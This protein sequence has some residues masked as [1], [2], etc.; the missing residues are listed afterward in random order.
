MKK[1]YK[2]TKKIIGIVL[3]FGLISCDSYLSELPDD[4]ATIDSPDKISAL[5][6]GAYPI[7]NYMLMAELMSDNALSKPSDNNVVDEQLHEQMF[8]WETNEDDSGNQDTPTNYWVSC[9]E[10]IGQANQALESIAELENIHNLNAQKGEALLARAYAHFMLVNFWGKHYN[11][12]SAST[13][14]GVPYVKET[15]TVLFK[16]YKRN[17]V[18]EV[19]DFIEAD[20]IQGIE[21]VREREE[22]PKFHFTTEAAHAFAA[23]FYAFKADWDKVIAHAN[24]ILTNPR[25]QIRDMIAYSDLTY[26]ARVFRYNNTIENAN[27]LVN[28]SLSWW[29]R[30]FASSNYGLVSGEG[31]G[32]LLGG[33]PL[34]KSWAYD[35]FGGELF[36][37]LPKFE[38]F[39]KITN[40]SAGSGTGFTPQVL[41]SYD[42]VLLNRAEAYAMKEDYANSLKDLTDFLSKKT[43]NFNDATDNLTTA[44]IANTFRVVPDYLTPSYGFSSNQQ[45]LFITAILNFKQK[46]FYHEGLRWFDVRKFNIPIIR[47]F[48]RGNLVTEI[49]LAKEDV[50][51][52]LQIPASASNLGLTKN[53]R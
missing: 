32:F 14:L 19:Y 50:R 41:F 20:L 34:N 38:E 10:A 30:D 18:K 27:I 1:L 47:D 2:N 35:V 36:S 44:M 37:N 43:I 16:N 13:D 49:S 33:N 25:L 21:L 22:N 48:R 52:Q 11:A 28:S 42:E 46:E 12:N 3:F 51:K 4:R 8:S 9:Y 6:T 40:Q 45:A 23:R 5:I 15:E 29:A 7:G 17:T 53:P 26:D 39:F 24:Q 31:T